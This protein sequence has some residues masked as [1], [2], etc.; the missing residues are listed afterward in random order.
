MFLRE[1][2]PRKEQFGPRLADRADALVRLRADRQVRVLRDVEVGADLGWRGLED[3]ERDAVRRVEEPIALNASIEQ[4]ALAE[5]THRDS[6]LACALTVEPRLDLFRY[7]A[8]VN[9][10]PR[11]HR[12]LVPLLRL[13][14][15][16]IVERDAQ[17]CA[18][19][20]R[21]V[22][23][24]ADL[25]GREV[26][27]VGVQ[28]LPHHGDAR[29]PLH[30]GA[31]E[32]VVRHYRDLVPIGCKAR[33]DLVRLCSVSRGCPRR[34]RCPTDSHGAASSCCLSLPPSRS[35]TG[36]FDLNR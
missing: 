5:A 19:L 16:D 21:L 20:G 34:V 12:D 13:V 27:A 17:P 7:D 22:D 9:G 23:P 3:I 31:S 6:P 1:A 4:L 29:S 10:R 30:R 36:G 15:P 18:I 32:A 33:D 14:D 11:C 28:P 35:P 25:R 8:V 24:V 26:I 2:A